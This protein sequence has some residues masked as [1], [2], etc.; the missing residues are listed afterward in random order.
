MLDDHHDTPG[1]NTRR[2]PPRF[3]GDETEEPPAAGSVDGFF[4][5]LEEDVG[6]PEMLDHAA[7]EAS[8][9]AK[10]A[11][12]LDPFALVSGEQAAKRKSVRRP[13]V[14][15]DEERLLDPRF[16]IPHLMKLAKE[17]K[18]AGKGKER[19]DLQRLMKV[20]RLWTH[21]MYPKGAFRDT[22]ESVGKL[23]HKRK[24]RDALRGWR[25]ESSTG[26]AKK[27]KAR[28]GDAEPAEA[29][30]GGQEARGSSEP[31]GL[32]RPAEEGSGDDVQPGV[33]PGGSAPGEGHDWDDLYQ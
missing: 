28:P 29:V 17:F 31:A 2:E 5:D 26:G 32:F 25:E 11:E 19:E 21:S 15:M 10:K 16:G 9:A 18:P 7:I 4:Q 6:L 14:K 20:Y 30:A 1:T 23:C 33:A 3:M 22:I 13:V 27:K 24:M 8:L 12:G